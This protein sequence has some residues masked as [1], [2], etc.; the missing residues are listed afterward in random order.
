MSLTR[1]QSL[2]CTTTPISLFFQCQ[3]S[4][5]PLS[6]SVATFVLIEIFCS[7][8]NDTYCI[9]YWRMFWCIYRKLAWV[10]FEPTTTEF[11]SDN[12]TEL[13]AHEFNSHSE[14]TLYSYSNFIVC[15][16]SNFISAI[17]FVSHHACFNWNLLEVITWYICIKNIYV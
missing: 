4:F 17:A 8:V 14:P 5:R 13:S 11:R 15:S 9:Y 7:R 10:G 1:T 2:L 6:L 16:V 12:F 3:V